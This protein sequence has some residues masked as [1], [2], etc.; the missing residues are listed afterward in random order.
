LPK[1]SYTE[2]VVTE[3]AASMGVVTSVARFSRSYAYVVVVSFCSSVKS[4]ATRSNAA[5]PR[6]TFAP[7]VYTMPSCLRMLT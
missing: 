7:L 2:C 1:A 3:V 5:L 4:A 6:P